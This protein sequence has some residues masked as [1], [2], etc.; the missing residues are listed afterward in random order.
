RDLA[1]ALEEIL[2]GKPV[3]KP[4]TPVAGCLIGRASAPKKDGTVTYAKHVARILQSNCQECHR[5]GQIGPMPL[6]TYDDAASWAGTIREVV[7]E[8]RMPPW[9]ADPR[10]GKFA[11]DRRLSAQDKETLLAWVAQGTP[12]GDDRDLPRPREFVAGWK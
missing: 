9:H 11:N 5:P 6:L 1:L 12:R 8:E 10:H 4:T 7:E 2:A 3:S